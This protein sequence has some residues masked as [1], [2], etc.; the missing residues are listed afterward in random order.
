MPKWLSELDKCKR[1]EMIFSMLLFMEEEP[2]L[3]ETLLT[4]VKFFNQ[5]F[6][7][8]EDQKK[9]LELMWYCARL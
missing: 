2:D 6:A 9:Y 1:D 8:A 3:S 7:S 4:A 5:T